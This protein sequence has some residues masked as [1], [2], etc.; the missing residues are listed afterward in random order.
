MS[1]TRNPVAQDRAT[2]RE[3]CWTG[4]SEK[5]RIS[6]VWAVGRMHCYTYNGFTDMHVVFGAANCSGTS[7]RKEYPCYVSNQLSLIISIWQICIMDK[8]KWGFSTQKYSILVFRKQH[9]H[10]NWKKPYY[11]KSKTTT[12]TRRITINLCVPESSIWRFVHTDELV[13]NRV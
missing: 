3:D 2:D 12:S 10:E 4:R 6:G 1:R 7:T 5:K 13:R 11:L 8:A 9:G